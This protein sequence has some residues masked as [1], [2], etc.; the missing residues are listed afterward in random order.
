L[1]GVVGLALWLGIR[2]GLPWLRAVLGGY[3]RVAVALAVVAV[4]LVGLCLVWFP[5]DLWHRY[6]YTPLFDADT[7]DH[8]WFYHQWLNFY[9]PT[10]WPLF[11]LVAF[12]ALASRPRPALF[13][14]CLFAAGF[15]LLSF[16][17]PKAML[18]A[19]FILP[20]LFALWG[21]AFA[22]VWGR[23]SGFIVE[24]TDGALRGLG[25]VPFPALETALITAAVGFVLLANTATIRTATMLAGITVPPEMPAPRWGEAADVLEPWL[26][27][28][29]VV[30]TS[31]ELD[32]LYYIGDYDVLLE[33]SRLSEQAAPAVE[34]SRD[35]RT[36]RPV[37]S[38]PESV[39]RIMDCY[40]EG[41]IVI[42]QYRWRRFA[43]IDGATADLIV[44]RT[45]PIP[46]P[47]RT[48]ILAFHWANSEPS[49]SDACADLILLVR[50]DRGS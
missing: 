45:D 1:I 13:C 26:R 4:A 40:A 29:A 9:Y 25:I 21:M 33:K 44:Q 43:Y 17:G 2:V 3:T 11:P 31:S 49:P 12:A 30:I 27:R 41:V 46:L 32:A 39:K 20:F 10:L 34:F 37:V 23:V 7:R 18:Y 42:D 15:L 8:F 19:T 38:T 50:S 14:L 24:V 35:P 5:S 47:A 36:G 6:R 48:R 16:G 28:E 22:Y